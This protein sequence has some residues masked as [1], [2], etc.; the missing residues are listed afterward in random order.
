MTTF[1]DDRRELEQR[2]AEFKQEIEPP[3]A[4]LVSLGAEQLK[5]IVDRLI[6]WSGLFSGF[7]TRSHAHEG[8]NE[9]SFPFR[10][11]QILHEIDQYTIQYSQAYHSRLVASTQSASPSTAKPAA[12]KSQPTAKQEADLYVRRVY[13]QNQVNQRKATDLYI[14][15]NEARMFGRTLVVEADPGA[16]YCGLIHRICGENE[17]GRCKKQWGHGASGT[18][19]V[20]ACSRCGM[21]FG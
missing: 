15:R 18:D 11:M 7:S 21:T 20:H 1:D 12:A 16:E 9:Y 14:L 2:Y 19:Y 17:H 6:F 4:K 8:A 13:L 5:S 10:L 3:G